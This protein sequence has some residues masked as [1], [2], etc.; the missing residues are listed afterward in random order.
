MILVVGGVASGKRTYARGLGYGQTGFASAADVVAG[1]VRAA[2]A[3]DA[4]E[5][6]H[7]ADLDI[8]AVARELA[9]C[10]VVLFTEVSSGVVPADAAQRAWRERA[11]R[12]SCKLA[13]RADTVVR[14]V[15]GVPVM[16]KG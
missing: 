5:L 11:G 1:R 6:A 10:D 12:L 8:E 3:V 4:Q 14:M 16:L 9:K 13:Q 2:V 7:D 15:C